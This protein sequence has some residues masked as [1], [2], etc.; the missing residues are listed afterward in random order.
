MS[1]TRTNSEKADII[2]GVIVS[3][4]LLVALNPGHIFFI[5]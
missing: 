1:K 5:N 2:A 4:L 3:F